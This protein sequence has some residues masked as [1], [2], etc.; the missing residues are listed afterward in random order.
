MI[1]ASVCILVYTWLILTIHRRTKNYNLPDIYAKSL[2]KWGG[3]FFSC[4][5]ML[6]VLLT[7][8]ESAGAEA[9]VM[10]TGFQL[11]TPVWVFIMVTAFATVY[12]VKKASPR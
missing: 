3:G 2:G 8:F 6:T 4:L 1:A 9:S 5:F 7:I 10:H 11:F 12:V